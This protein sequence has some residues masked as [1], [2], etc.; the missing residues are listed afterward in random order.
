MP[1]VDAL[2][3]RHAAST[4]RPR[5]LAAGA[6]RTATSG[7][8][9]FKIVEVWGIPIGLHFS[10]YLALGLF[11]WSLATGYFPLEYPGWQAATYWI[12]GLFTCGLFFASILIHELGH[13]WVA[14][15]NGLPIRRITL[16]VFG[17]VAQIGREPDSPGVELRIAIAGPITSFGLAAAAAGVWLLTRELDVIAAPAIWL[18]RVNAMVAAF[19]LIPGFPLDGGRVFRALVWRWTGNFQRATRAASA[20]GQLVASGFIA[21]GL[22]VA[23]RGNA[24][25]GIWMVFIGWFLQSAATGAQA[26]ASLRDLLRGVKVAHAMTRAWA[27]VDPGWTLER[28]VQEEILGAGQRC[29]FV[30]GDGR[31]RGL[32]TLHEIKSVPR[33]QW[34]AVRVEDVARAAETLRRVGP[35]DDLLAALEMID[36]AG[37]GQLPVVEGDVLVGVI[38]R[39]EILRY[40][41]ARAEL[42]L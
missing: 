37:V 17:G 11:T 42:G 8:G 30:V 32:L 23:L 9:F 19:N 16:F 1:P 41:R 27:Q 5:V 35:Q 13:S 2:P 15:R 7:P 38:G 34:R 31:F 39:E 29:F 4:S 36:D 28:V 12:V 6:E 14:L 18:A 22:L 26:Q 3:D 33:D 24:L 21:L 25:G 10:W 20:A 40:V